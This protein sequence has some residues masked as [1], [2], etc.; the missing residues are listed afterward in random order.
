MV[1]KADL[2][3]HSC[4]S[5]CGDL[6]MSPRAIV[7]T[8]VKKQIFLAAL[9][10][11][12]TCLNT[13]P[14]AALCRRAGIAVLYGM[15]A[16]TAEEIH[17]LV[18]FNDEK[19]AMAFSAAWYE[20]LPFVRN[21]PEKTG[22]QV[23]VNETDEI[24][25]EVEKYLIT[26]STCDL[27]SLEKEVHCLGGLVIPAHIDRSSFSLISQLGVVPDGNWDALECVRLSDCPVL[28]R[29]YPVITGSDAHFIEHIGRRAFF[30]DT[31]I[32][33]LTDCTGSVN[34]SALRAG[35]VK[36]VVRQ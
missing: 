26:S 14:F 10:D 31:G 19:T 24:C 8:L 30:I 29:P 35:L 5:P 32:L 15:E 25:G 20:T 36:Y 22:D 6:S 9:T 21:R 2:H 28:P 4:L 16:Q 33:P 3:L 27:E 34:L 11:H 23:Y 17:V 1:V 7:D 12:N 13:P 18:L